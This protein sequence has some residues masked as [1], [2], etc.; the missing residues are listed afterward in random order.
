MADYDI[1]NFN[2]LSI[3]DLYED[4]E[5]FRYVLDNAVGIS[6]VQCRTKLV[7]DGFTSIRSIIRQHPNDVEGFKTYLLQ[8]NKTFASSSDAALRVYYSPV[9][10]SRLLGVVH[11]YNQAVNTFHS[12]PDP[13]YLDENY[14]DDL[15]AIY[16][17]FSEKSKAEKDEV[18]I[19]L[20]KLTGSS[21]WI[22]FKEKFKMK[23]SLKIGN[24]GIPLSYVIDTTPRAVTRG[25]AN[26]VEVDRI[27]VDDD[28]FNVSNATQFGSVYKR[29]NIAVWNMLKS[30]LL[31]TPVYNHIAS[32]DRTSNGHRAWSLM[33]EFY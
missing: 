16:N 27:E 2:T 20:P 13:S 1:N 17:A 15:A 24:R 5:L 19:D 6:Q 25:N 11:L 33:Q 32:C 7:D 31:G 26:L 9:V 10:I 23:L 14:A 28:D 8:L 18:E 21:N 30:H 29:D 4:E 3:T 22:D 12:I